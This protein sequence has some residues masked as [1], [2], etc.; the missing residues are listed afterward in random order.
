MTGLQLATINISRITSEDRRRLLLL[1]RLHFLVL[2]LEQDVEQDGV[3]L[4]V[5]RVVHKLALEPGKP[6][7]LRQYSSPPEK[8]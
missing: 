6:R 5:E 7:F 1:T 3:R 2:Q 4:E 8:N